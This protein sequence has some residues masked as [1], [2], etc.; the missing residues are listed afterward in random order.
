MEKQVDAGRTRTIGLSNYNISQIQNVLESA[1]IKP[2][3]LQVEIHVFLQQPDL[4]DFCHK[5]GI[6]VVAYAPLGTPGYNNLMAQLGLKQ[7]EL[8]NILTNSVVNKIAK[9]HSKTSAQ[10]ALRYL[11]Q[12]GLAAIPKS[13]N[14]NRIKENFHV[15]DF[16]LDENDLKE[17]KNLDQNH[18]V[19]GFVDFLPR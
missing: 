13:V 6:T 11:L 15:F 10:V 14:A 19:C 8:P 1:R 18:R 4:V 5:S 7:K 2:A 9:K 12:L 17:L 16:R 3:N